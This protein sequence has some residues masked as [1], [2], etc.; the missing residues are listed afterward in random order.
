[1]RDWR[2]LRLRSDCATGLIRSIRIVISMMMHGSVLNVMAVA[3]AD[4]MV[5][6]GVVTDRIAH[7]AVSGMHTQCY[8][9]ACGQ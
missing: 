3:D 5:I 1:M 4:A 2:S 8:A 6:A 7:V 9:C